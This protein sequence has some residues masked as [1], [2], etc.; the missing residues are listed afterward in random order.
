[1]FWCNLSQ[2]TEDKEVCFTWKSK[3][4]RC[5]FMCLNNKEYKA[6][7]VL[8]GWGG[9]L[10][11]IG[12]AEGSVQHYSRDVCTGDYSLGAPKANWWPMISS[13][14]TH[15]HF[16]VETAGAPFLLHDVKRKCKMDKL[17]T[18]MFSSSSCYCYFSESTKKNYLE[19]LVFASLCTWWIWLP[20]Y[21]LYLNLS[22]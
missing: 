21:L 6:K 20:F 14:I 19:L 13:N 10:Y 11:C 9:H 3:V 22:A 18:I 15:T 1:M 5:W 12:I 2:K 4:I 7:P 17:S 8:A 16:Q